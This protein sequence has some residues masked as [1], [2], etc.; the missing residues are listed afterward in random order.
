MNKY[1]PLKGKPHM[2][3]VMDKREDGLA[4]GKTFTFKSGAAY[5]VQADGSVRSAQRKLRGKSYRKQLKQIRR[6]AREQVAAAVNKP[7]PAVNNRCPYHATAP[8]TDA[9]TEKQCLLSSGH[10]GDHQYQEVQS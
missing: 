5:T 6:Q 8:G 2:V 7:A 10:E 1:D 3:Q 9:V 4:V